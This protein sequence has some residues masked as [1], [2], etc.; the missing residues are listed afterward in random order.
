M[1][2]THCT[3]RTPSQL[4]PYLLLLL[5][6]RWGKL[7]PSQFSC[8]L[9]GAHRQVPQVL[10]AEPARHP[11]STMIKPGFLPPKLAS[12][13]SHSDRQL[14][15][16]GHQPSIQLNPEKTSEKW[17][18]W[19]HFLGHC[20]PQ[21]RA[22]VMPKRSPGGK[23]VFVSIIYVDLNVANCHGWA[24]C[25]NIAGFYFV[26]RGTIHPIWAESKACRHPVLACCLLLLAA[27]EHPV[28]T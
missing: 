15:A 2:S 4:L 18:F 7:Q 13:T 24:F 5:S 19:R 10:P 17:S 25:P 8:A 16:G 14:P 6:R 1:H 27:L 21:T 20:E 11:I 3:L 23:E 22:P 26:L 9:R 28:T 12:V